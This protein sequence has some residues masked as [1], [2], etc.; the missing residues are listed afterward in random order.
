VPSSFEVRALPGTGVGV[1]RSVEER[2]SRLL[3]EYAAPAQLMIRGPQ[4]PVM[5]GSMNFDRRIGTG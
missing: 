5:F 1:E 3:G 2:I 4:Q